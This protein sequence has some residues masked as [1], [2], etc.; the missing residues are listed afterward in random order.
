MFLEN[1]RLFISVNINDK[2]I[3]SALA[4]VQSH[5]DFKGVKLVDPDLFHFSL[6]FLGDTSENLIP[7]LSQVISSVKSAPF[8]IS[9]QGVGVFP[10]LQKI[11][12]IWAGVSE[13]ATELQS[14]KN[15]L[16][17]PLEKLGFTVEKRPFTPHL[18][19]GRVKFVDS[20][21]KPALQKILLENQAKK[22]GSQQALS[23]HLMQ[24]TLKPEGP[25]Y[26]SLFRHDL[27]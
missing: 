13:G 20:A 7:Q 3:K 15:Q 19:I 12:V 27:S 26:Q 21:Q 24:S 10:S 16:D 11:K 17:E 5:L 4:D 9:L 6:H 22:L 23:I 18:T 2:Q 14:I 1:L 25:S 8:T